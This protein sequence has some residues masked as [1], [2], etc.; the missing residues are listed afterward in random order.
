MLYTLG[1][2]DSAELDEMIQQFIDEENVDIPENIGSYDY[3]D[4]LGITLSW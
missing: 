2:R 1:L 3:E 4:F